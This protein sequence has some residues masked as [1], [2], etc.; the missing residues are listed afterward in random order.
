MQTLLVL[1]CSSYTELPNFC[2]HI[3]SF[4]PLAAAPARPQFHG[5][6]NA[7]M[8]QYQT[9]IGFLLGELVWQ[10]LR[11][12]DSRR[13]GSPACPNFLLASFHPTAST[14]AVQKVL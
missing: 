6:T 2:L 5:D 12:L 13:S 3:L 11:Q 14:P 9:I 7:F 8:N 10:Q 1:Y 4:L